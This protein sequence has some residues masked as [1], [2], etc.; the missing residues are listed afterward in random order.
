MSQNFNLDDVLKDAA[1]HWLKRKGRTKQKPSENPQYGNV[2]NLGDVMKH[3]VL[4]KHLLALRRRFGFRV[5]YRD[6]HA[7]LLEAPPVRG[8]PMAAL[9]HFRE[10]PGGGR[11]GGLL[12]YQTGRPYRCSAGRALDVLGIPKEPGWWMAFGERHR[13]T[14]QR[15]IGQLLDVG[16]ENPGTKQSGIAICNEARDV[17]NTPIPREAQ[18]VVALFDPFK[19]DD[20]LIV[21]IK[22]WA[23]LLPAWTTCVIVM[24]GYGVQNPVPKFPFDNSQK[25]ITEIEISS[26][27]HSVR[28]VEFT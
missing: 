25:I 3:S 23:K 20:Q 6:T 9:K 22:E 17:L 14:R 21:T 27:F 1:Q 11:D 5:A 10:M 18:A 4:T 2:G 24:Y 16:V 15:L 12:N 8:Q 28:T 7:F 13:S 26:C 19:W